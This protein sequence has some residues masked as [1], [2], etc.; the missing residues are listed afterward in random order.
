MSSPVSFLVQEKEKLIVKKNS[1]K[2]FPIASITKLFTAF[3]ALSLYSSSKVFKVPSSCVIKNSYESRAGLR[4]NE[5]F[6]LMA[7][8]EGLLISSGN[9]AACVLAKSYKTG[10]KGFM[11]EV[12]RFVQEK[13]LKKTRLLEPVGLSSHSVSSAEELQKILHELEAYPSLL[14]I[15]KKK[16]SLIQSKKGRKIKLV[17]RQKLFSYRGYAIFG[18]TGTTRK[19]G[20]CFVGFAKRNDKFYYL[21]FLGSKNVYKD[22]R[23]ILLKI[24]GESSDS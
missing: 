1:E 21:I 13:G 20:E 15:L 4:K 22:I 7:L 9:D 3:T 16:Q 5:K 24:S 8:I 6:S 12:N 14:T 17:S 10:E 2:V 18:K 23:K 11:E 19:A